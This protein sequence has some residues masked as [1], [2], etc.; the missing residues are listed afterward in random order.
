MRAV[1]M[2]G[3]EGSRLRPLTSLQP[4]PMVPIVNQPVMEHIIGLVKHHGIT[5]I[6]ATLAFMPQ[7]IQD[8][9]GDG[10]EWGTRMSYALE[11]TPLGTAGSVKNAEALLGG[12]PFIVISGD[13]LTDIDLTHV[14]EFHRS[15]GAAVTIALK[16]MPDPLEFGVVIT[17]GNGRIERF[18]EKPS[19]GQVFSD[20]INTGIYVV[21]PEV[22][23]HIPE[24]TPFD[25]SSELFPLLMEKGYP[26]YGCVVD[27]YWCDVGSF[28][29]YMQA[30]RDVL[31]GE[32]KVFIPGVQT[33]ERVWI[34]EGAR[35]EPGVVIGDKVVIG[36]NVTLRA[37]AH[38]GDYTVLGDNCVIGNEANVSHS[39]LWSDTFLGRHSSVGGSVLC[40]RV[41][42][43]AGATVDMNTVIGDESMVGHGARVGA[44]IQ[45]F[46]YKRIEPAA[47]VTSSI[48]W[49]STGSKSL[50]GE[51]GISGLVGVD[52]TPERSM[53]AAQAFGTMLPKGSHVVVSRD[54]SR[55]ARMVKRA[56]VAGLN[57]AGCHVRDLR[58]AS[59]A[60]TRFTARDTRCAGG[61]H[62]AASVEDPQS[63]RMCF[64]D[65]DGLDIAPWSEK[66]LERLYF[67]GEFRRAF[68][69]DVG[70][71]LYPPRALEYYSA[72]LEKALEG[73][74]PTEGAWI[75]VVADLGFGVSS[76]VLPRVA[77]AWRVNMV[78]L[79]P[80]IDAERMATV[81]DSDT[82]WDEMR[83][84]IDLY[85]ADFGVRFDPMAE[86]LTFMTASGR[87]LD[88]DTA[89]HTL[90]DLWCRSDSTAKPI[91]VPLTA[92]QVVEDI[93]AK[94]GHQVLR[95][96]RT[97]RS[98]SV[99]AQEEVIGFAGSTR[100]GYIFPRFLA[101]YDGVIC[102]AMVASMLSCGS[103]GLDEIVEGLPVFHKG[104]TSVF[105]PAHRKGAVMR[106]VSETSSGADVD[107]TEGVRIAEEGGWALVLPHSSEPEVTVWAEGEDEMSLTRI[108][109]RWVKVVKEAI[110]PE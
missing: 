77:S 28:E 11:E 79:N 71:I 107:L 72:G 105:C 78:A 83:G 57:A 19:W 26:L 61:I 100:G 1:I 99:L 88:G 74:L 87:V 34:D 33:R 20:T 31:D 37:G 53:R 68:L 45:I 104:Q 41:D 54:A 9:F 17:D 90:V 101:A 25:F 85:R 64:Y 23:S 47:V 39:V 52:I 63:L 80:F 81:S 96:G 14:I 59:P 73:A 2:A 30:H 110:G 58:V 62:V 35:I 50:F 55:G 94:T 15:K 51:D 7:V 3:G 43:R 66:K 109:D 6:V 44:N 12:D 16:S 86:R 5:D 38:V 70:E 36:P 24:G 8:Y 69:E 46:P 82:G 106:A 103:V 10:E 102:V 22:L 92:S 93:A 40:R 32:A 13:A 84:M 67:K 27:G 49:E 42:I 21:E 89:L 18:L 65:T 97:R 56:M 76:L 98:L 29:S 4:K 75:K 108:M 95:P 48:I 91:A 60:L